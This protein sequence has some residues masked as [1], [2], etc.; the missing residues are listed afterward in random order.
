MFWEKHPEI[1]H[2]DSNSCLK[3][4][5]PETNK[6]RTKKQ[7]SLNFGSLWIFPLEMPSKDLIGIDIDPTNEIWDLNKKWCNIFL[8][9]W[10]KTKKT[11]HQSSIMDIGQYR[12]YSIKKSA[13]FVFIEDWKSICYSIPGLFEQ[14]LMCC[15]VALKQNSS[16]ESEEKPA[17]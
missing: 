15:S 12:Q 11:N 3:A 17:M 10:N 5:S 2:H 9:Q 7:T 4:L 13:G 8:K 6:R 16:R 14:S 1:H